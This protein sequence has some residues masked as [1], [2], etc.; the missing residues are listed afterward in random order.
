MRAQWR[1]LILGS[2]FLAGMSSA[3][4]RGSHGGDRLHGGE[5][6]TAAIRAARL[7]QNVAIVQN[8]LD[9]IASFWTDDVVLT[10]GLGAVTQGRDAYRSLFQHDSVMYQRLPEQIEASAT[11]PLAF[12]S[13]SWVGRS[14]RSGKPMIFGRYS[15]Q[16]LK[17]DGRWLIHSEVFVALG[18][19]GDGC[20]WSTT[21]AK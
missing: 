8:D 17:R 9:R 3:L 4:P 7:A 18:C 20:Q 19:A 5:T 1:V 12:E 11:W 15:A 16:W 6:D 2:V 10:R 14:V 21:F 13:G